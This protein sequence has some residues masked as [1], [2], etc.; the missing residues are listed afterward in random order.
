M[1]IHY[2]LT[3]DV[4]QAN[5]F[6]FEPRTLCKRAEEQDTCKESKCPILKGNEIEKD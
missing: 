4:F 6:W 1:I 5:C 3:F 2:K